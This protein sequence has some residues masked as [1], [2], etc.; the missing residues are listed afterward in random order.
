MPNGDGERDHREP[1]C[2]GHRLSHATREIQGMN[3]TA[4]DP[5]PGSFAI[6]RAR[7]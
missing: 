3:K 5:I 6:Q 4:G 1:Y 2:P 7:L